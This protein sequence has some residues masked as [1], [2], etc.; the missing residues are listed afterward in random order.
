MPEAG[1]RAPSGPNPPSDHLLDNLPLL[2]EAAALGPIVDLACGRGRHAIELA[3]QGL[4]V[5]GL[6]RNAGFLRELA[7]R[8]A[9]LEGRVECV[10]CDL[11]GAQN[12]PVKPAT[13]GAVL[14]YRFLYRP[15]S[16]AIEALLAPGGLLLYE[17]FTLGQAERDYGPSNPDFL[18]REG[19]LPS[20]FPNLSIEQHEELIHGAPR[21][22]AIAR[23]RARRPRPAT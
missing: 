3:R 23:L 2:R 6:D 16:P 5:V 9:P 22:D 19:E 14:V 10:R 15:L 11:E 12:I 1:R 20:L 17:T 21:P 8:S 18:L 7:A 4:R 13:C